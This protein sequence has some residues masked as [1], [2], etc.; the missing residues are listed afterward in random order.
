MCIHKDSI[1]IRVQGSGVTNDQIIF[2]LVMRFFASLCS[3][4]NDS[5]MNFENPTISDQKK[6]LIRQK[7]SYPTHYFA[8]LVSC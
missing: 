4:L 5:C 6:F 7:L 8:D 3:A 1:K 2:E